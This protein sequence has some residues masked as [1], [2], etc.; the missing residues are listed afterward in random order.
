MCAMRILWFKSACAVVLALLLTANVGAAVET[1]RV[2]GTGGA[3][4]MIRHIATE[5]A[6]AT[7]NRIEIIPGLGSKGAIRATADGVLDLTVSAR[8]LEPDET[9]RGLTAV[10]FAR[11]ALVFVTS[12][13][14]PNSLS[15]NDI[16]EIFKSADPKWA[17]GSP[18]RLILRTRF[19]G[20]TLILEQRFAGMREAI[21]Q[22]RKR[23]EI[24]IAATDQ[25]S[26]DLA[27][28]VSGSLVQ[29]GL[30]QIE[31]EKRNL[32]YVPI[33]G[34]SPRLAALEKGEYPY[35][36]PFFLVFSAERKAAA[37]GLLDFL[38]SEKGR[39]VLRATGNIPA[40]E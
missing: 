20:D 34:V 28:R 18:I 4:G 24:P 32:R 5:Y 26:A 37:E 21:A 30:S 27:E 7:G 23:P 12:K 15:I 6:A 38:K 33:D 2:S 3:L 11:T 8:P 1:L 17:D 13:R 36:K 22:A 16:I 25:D 14:D 19:D 40:T 9:A 39:A 10:Q 35:E 29:A 31:T